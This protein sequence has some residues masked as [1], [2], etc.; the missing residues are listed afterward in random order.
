MNRNTNNQILVPTDFSEVANNALS[1]AITVAKAYGNGITLVSVVEE[2]FLGGLFS[3]NQTNLI[4]EA[5]EARL[6]KATE[7][8]KTTHN[9]NIQ[10]RVETGKVYKKIAEIANNEKF[11]SII[12]GSHGASGLEQVIGSNASRTLQ[13]AEVPVVVV[14]NQPIR[15]GYKKI[16]MPIDMSIESRQKVDWAIHLASKFNSEVHIVYT[17][18]TDEFNANRINA[19]IKLVEHELASK[20]VKFVTNEIE[21]KMLEN[22]GTEVLTYAENVNADLIL[23]MT[24]TEKGLSEMV[25][26]TLTQQMVNRSENIPVMCIHPHETGFT[27][28]Y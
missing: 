8:I 23:V 10:T 17:G 20:G 24:H 26:G 28:D 27:Y 22:F 3:G 1:H 11:D 14:K 9:L 5:L 4:K 16:V 25:I 7:E 15:E 21:D 19:A 13:H 2:S 18:S 12:M 6:A